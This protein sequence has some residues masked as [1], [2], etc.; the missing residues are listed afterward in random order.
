MMDPY[1]HMFVKHHFVGG[2]YTKEMHIPPG[3]RLEQHRHTFDHQSILVSGDAIVEVDGEQ[4]QY[5]GPSMLTIAAKKVHS[6]IALTP[7][8]WLCQHVTSC[9]DPENIDAEFIDQGS[10]Q[11]PQ[12]SSQV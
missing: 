7:V 3:F 9:T 4:T 11:C 2:I 5:A 10:P 12:H 1:K 8:V 6:I